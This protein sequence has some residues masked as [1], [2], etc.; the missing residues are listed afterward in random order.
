[1]KQQPNIAK[2][3]GFLTLA[4]T[5]ISLLFIAAPVTA[6]PISTT[7]TLRSGGSTQTAG[8]TYISPF[9]LQLN[10][11]IYS[12]GTWFS[13]P[14]IANPP[15]PWA[16]IPPAQWVSTTASF[17][18]ADAEY[19]G[20]AWRLFQDQFTIPG[21]ATITSASI[22][23]AAD[24]AFEVYLNGNLIATTADWDPIAT[25]YGPSPVFAPAAPY[26]NTTSY[27]VT[28]QIGVN[29]FMFVVR[30]WSIDGVGNPTGLLY[31]ASITYETS[32]VPPTPAVIGGTVF[33]VD[34]FQLL[35]PWLGIGLGVLMALSLAVK[36]FSSET[37][38]TSPTVSFQAAAYSR[39]YQKSPLALSLYDCLT[40]FNNILTYLY[41]ILIPIYVYFYTAMLESK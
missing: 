39:L 7:I 35:L 32:S 36:G 37:D 40:I 34:K 38:S 1:M 30:N 8:Y 10:P 18:G 24:N 3:L 4:L 28:P 31:S 17:Y 22:Q 41:V 12:N 14:V 11:A 9:P 16:Q 26:L 33:K 20:D 15:G 21:G 29:T 19:P 6:A 25:V 13:A 23:V 27:S 2:K 5:I